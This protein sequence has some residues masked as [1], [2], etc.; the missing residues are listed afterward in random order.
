MI[1]ANTEERRGH[2]WNI[3]E[4]VVLSYLNCDLFESEDDEREKN[5]LCSFFL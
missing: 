2:G 3:I 4:R 1:L 5:R